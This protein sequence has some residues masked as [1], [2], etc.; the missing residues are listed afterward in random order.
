[1]MQFNIVIL[2]TP[3]FNKWFV[4]FT[5]LWSPCMHSVLPTTCHMPHPSHPLWFYHPSYIWSGKQT[6]QPLNINFSSLLLL[7][8][9]F[10]L[11]PNNFIPFSALFS[12]TPQPSLTVTDQA[13]L[14]YKKKWQ[15]ST[16][17]LSCFSVANATTKYVFW[18]KWHVAF[19]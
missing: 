9:L 19:P 17:S 7:T 4:Y 8:P 13:T 2:S 14:P 6:I 3:S 12:N 5:C 10:H 16:F 18:I 1:M 15:F 11:R